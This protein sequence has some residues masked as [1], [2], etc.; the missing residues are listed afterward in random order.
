SAE[1]MEILDVT[2]AQ[3][4]GLPPVILNVREDR[5]T[6]D[7]AEELKRVLKAHPGKAPVHMSLT[8]PG[9]NKRLVLN[10]AP[11][12]VEPGSSFM[13]DIKQLLGPTCIAS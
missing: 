11:F 3:N 10:L 2:T 4:G 5:I 6:R 13:A 12:S 7:L 9:R 1:Q 8:R